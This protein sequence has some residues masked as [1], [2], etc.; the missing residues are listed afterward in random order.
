MDII[1]LPAAGVRAVFRDALSR[2]T[3]LLIALKIGEHVYSPTTK[4]N[5]PIIWIGSQNIDSTRKFYKLSTDSNESSLLEL[6][7]YYE[8]S[9]MLLGL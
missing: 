1:C 8:L 3:T 2:C 9:V 5:I 4:Q 6:T 7:S